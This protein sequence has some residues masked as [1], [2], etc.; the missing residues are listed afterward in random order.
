ME[1]IS[2]ITFLSKPIINPKNLK[3]I[4]QIK[5]VY[6]NLYQ[7]KLSKELTVYQ[8]PFSVS[9]NIT[10]GDSRIRSILFKSCNKE[11]KNTYGECLI[12]GDSLYSLKKINEIK[13]FKS[14]TYLKG[15]RD[16]YI[17]TF[18]K[19][20]NERKI[21]NEEVQKD[22][23]SK[24]FIE[25]LVKDILH[26][27]PNLDFYKGFFVLSTSK[28]TIEANGVSINFYPGFTTS[29]VET[30]RGN[31]LNVTLKNK[32]IQSENV[33]DFLIDYDY[34]DKDNYNNIKEELV[35]REFKVSYAK[36]HY[37]IEDILFDRN[38]EN[39]TF[40]FKGKNYKL[41]DYFKDEYKIVI[42]NPKQPII[43]VRNKAKDGQVTNSYFV[44]ELCYLSGL[45]EEETKN[46]LFMKELAKLTKLEPNERIQKT[47]EF[48]KLLEDPSKDKNQPGKLSAK[49][50]SDLYGIKVEPLNE[51]FTAY[52]MKDTKLIGGS[53]TQVSSKDKT[54]KVLKKSDLT[55][56]L[57]FYEENNYND[58][59]NLYN[60]LSKAS[61]AYGL[62]IPE[63]EWVEMKNKSSAKKWMETADEYFSEDKQDYSFALFLLGKNDSIYPQLKKHSL[64]RNGYVSQVVKARSIQ[65]KGGI[66]SV[67]SKILLQINAKLGGISYK[68]VINKEINDRK[69]MV[70]GV[71]S[72]HIKGK[73]TG[74]AMVS[75]INDSFTD[76]YNKEEIIKEENKEQLQFCISSFIEQAI[77]AYNKKNK[78]APKGIVIYRQ[79]VSLQQKEF[80]KTEIQQ[81]D[82]VCKT[83]NIL[84][85]YILVNTKTTFKFFEKSN[86]GYSNPGSGLLVIDGVTN[87]NYFEFYIQPQEVTQGSAT[88]TC[89]HVA[90]G[91]LDFPELIPKFTY[92]LCHI[93]S[94]WQGTIRIPNVIKAAEK[95]SKMTAKYKLDELNP[96]LKLGQAY[97]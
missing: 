21:K 91:N 86:K 93:Y 7:I 16:E 85:Y 92:D 9:P 47:N 30:D 61:K 87:R 24:Q 70:I 20:V 53:N 59:E 10:P 40:S 35:G 94:N 71:D 19:V 72:S 44:P 52:Y 43:L 54:F 77:V 73:R 23:L 22:Q 49:E 57:C 45:E 33:L 32:I 27:N 95:L 68:A 76:F 15:Q 50:K 84:Y 82:T 81:I 56:W 31:F 88:P 26:S 78:A 28:K 62:K 83:K 69:L 60:T 11:L 58:A 2:P 34:K 13:S 18:E 55:N 38:P 75:T 96:E 63:P 79:G 42:H 97:L 36:R 80:L 5:S 67:C 41:I 48:I 64:C 90:Y 1:S 14:N 39:Q 66:M 12:S 89:F 37:I 29:F 65:K 46:G 3:Y 8:Y 25:L 51:L 6:A 4:E 17:I 74:V